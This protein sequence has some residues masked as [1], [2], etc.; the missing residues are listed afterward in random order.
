[1]FTKPRA[2]PFISFLLLFALIGSAIPVTSAQQQQPQRQRRVA[3]PVK[4]VTPPF[5]PTPTPSPVPTVTPDAVR[6]EFPQASPLP[7]ATPA[8]VATKA[9][10]TRTL[11]ELQARISEVL[12]KPELASGMVG[13]K[14]ASL[15]TGKILFAENADKLLRPAS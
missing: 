8:V 4:T 14:V 11:A 6:T 2:V 9:A 13:I 10:T 12:R 15:D 5:T 3:S 7:T 1:M